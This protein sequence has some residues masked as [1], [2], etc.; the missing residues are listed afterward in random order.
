MGNKPTKF[1]GCVVVLCSWWML[2]LKHGGCWE[3]SSAE[4]VFSLM[5]S[6]ILTRGVSSEFQTGDILLLS[7]RISCYAKPCETISVHPDDRL[8]VCG[9]SSL[10][11]TTCCLSLLLLY[12]IVL[13]EQF[14]T[15]FFSS[16]PNKVRIYLAPNIF[17]IVCFVIIVFSLIVSCYHND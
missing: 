10:C 9:S 2:M 15:L 5:P 12:L 1:V 3:T 11:R 13:S 16:W 8:Q 7:H 17:A 4:L 6:P 14:F